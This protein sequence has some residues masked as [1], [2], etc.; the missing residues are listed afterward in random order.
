MTPSPEGTAESVKLGAGVTVSETETWCVKLPEVPVTVTVKVPMAASP[1]AVKVRALLV[2][3]GLGLK[4]AVTPDG[5]PEADSVTLPPKPFFG[6][7]VTV[8][9]LLD[10]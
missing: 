8:V 7:T 9:P 6:V 5:N 4:A 3:A 2:V 1:D 10:P